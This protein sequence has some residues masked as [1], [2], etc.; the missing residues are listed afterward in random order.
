MPSLSATSV[1]SYFN[2]IEHLLSI[3]ASY[4]EHLMA[5]NFDLLIVLMN[6]LLKFHTVLLRKDYTVAIPSAFGSL[7]VFIFSQ[8]G[9]QIFSYKK[10]LVIE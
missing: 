5:F 9:H 2:N 10:S 4:T 3:S 6:V 1:S 7:A 8:I